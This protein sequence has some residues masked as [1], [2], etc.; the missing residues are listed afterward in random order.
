VVVGDIAKPLTVGLA[1]GVFLSVAGAPALATVLFAVNPIAPAT[2][3]VVTMVLFA[4]GLTAAIVGAWQL[5][6]IDPIIALRAE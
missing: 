3:T 4:I 6:S 1:V 5:K 2:M